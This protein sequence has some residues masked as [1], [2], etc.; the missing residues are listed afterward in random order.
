MYA[1]LFKPRTLV[2]SY[3]RSLNLTFVQVSKY[4]EN[5][6]LVWENVFSHIG[7][8]LTIWLGHPRGLWVSTP[9]SY[10]SSTL[11]PYMLSIHSSSRAYPWQIACQMGR[12]VA[13]GGL[14]A[15]RL[16][17]FQNF[18]SKINGNANFSLNFLRI[19]RK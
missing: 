5:L 13:L 9:F 10:V 1:T 19:L 17:R 3:H 12:C 14:S 11:Y 7:I 6:T 18:P 16:L 2:P 4:P 8:D 15:A